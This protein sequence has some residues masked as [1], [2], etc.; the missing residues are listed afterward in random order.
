MISAATSMRGLQQKIDLIAHN[1]SN[2]QTVGYKRQDASFFD[3]LT[4]V[5]EQ[6]DNVILEGRRTP[7]GL[8][9]DWGSALSRTESDFTQGHLV[10]TDQPLD[11]AI[12]GQ[13]LFEIAH[14][15]LSATGEPLSDADG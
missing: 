9:L 3:L 13:A 10:Q 8:T 6:Q 12:E 1:V 5:Q 7:P 15:R 11:V 14:V 4:S 2:L